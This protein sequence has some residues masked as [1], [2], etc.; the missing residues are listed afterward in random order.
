VVFLPCHNRT[1]NGIVAAF[2]QV[3]AGTVFPPAPASSGT[4]PSS[5]SGTAPAASWRLWPR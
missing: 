2:R 1:E 4:L 3:L 5:C